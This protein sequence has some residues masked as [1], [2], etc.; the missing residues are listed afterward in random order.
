MKL[1]RAKIFWGISISKKSSQRGEKTKDY[2]KILNDPLQTLLCLSQKV[3]IIFNK[4]KKYFLNS[5]SRFPWYKADYSIFIKV[6]N[7][8][9]LA[10]IL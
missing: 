10:N 3:I 8:L 2:V 1:S 4:I 7:D 5:V 6:S 9:C